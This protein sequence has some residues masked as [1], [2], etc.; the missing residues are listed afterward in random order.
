MVVVLAILAFLAV[1]L[2][3]RY[4]AGTKSPVSGK[5][6]SAPIQRAHDVECMNYLRQLR[7]AIQMSQASSEALP[8]SL[9]ELSSSGVTREMLACP[10]SRMAYL[11]DPQTGR[12]GCPYPPH[13]SY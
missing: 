12:V 11:Y 1:W 5:T 4:L 7:A 2:V 6:V 9:S 8:R 3:P 13:R 10:V